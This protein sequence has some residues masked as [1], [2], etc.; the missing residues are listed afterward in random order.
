MSGIQEVIDAVQ[1]SYGPGR[2]RPDQRVAALP[3]T[4]FALLFK[5]AFNIAMKAAP[6][7]RRK[8]AR[9]PGRPAVSAE[10]DVRSALLDAAG[11]LF[12]KH[13]FERVTARQIAAGA[14]TTP[15][16]IHYYFTNKLGL[17]HAMLDRAIRPLREKLAGLLMQADGALDVPSLIT[18]HMRTVAANS[19]IP[20]F[21][22]NEVLAEKGR[23]RATFIREI[24]SRQLPLIVELLERGRVAGNFRADLD[25]RLAALSLLSLCMFPFLTRQVSAPVLGLSYEGDGLE[26]LIEHTAKVFLNGIANRTELRS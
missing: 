12:L 22:L 16:M 25:C 7:T 24:A 14:G 2:G 10:D 15:A 6:T 17:F 5:Q 20:V 19:W 9:M 8:R 1:W 26:Q 23:F 11:K 3:S 4:A 13:G 18:L 21:I